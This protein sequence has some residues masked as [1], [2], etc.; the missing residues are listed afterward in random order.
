MRKLSAWYEEKS[1]TIRLISVVISGVFLALSLGL[2]W[3]GK[4]A[5]VNPAWAAIV[6]CGVPIVAGAAAGLVR[7]KDITADVLV[8]IALIGSLILKEFFAAGEVAFI[9]QIGSILEDFT[10]ERAKKGI[11]KLLKL[12][13]QKA[14]L[15]ENGAVRVIGAESVKKGDIL[16]VRAGE[17]IPVDARIIEGSTSVNQSAMT[18]ESMPVEKRAGDEVMS[19]TI[20]ESGVIL[21]EATKTAR[22]SS[23]QRMIALAESADAQK[24]KI[25]RKANV[26]AAWLVVISLATAIIS[27]FVIAK[28]CGDGWLG[29]ER[30]VTVLVVFCPCA[31]VLA[32]PTAISAGIGNASKHGVLIQSGEAL[33]RLA[34][35]D[36]AIF[37][38]TG[39]LTSGKPVVVKTESTSEMSAEEILKI[40]ASGEA[41]STHPLAKA[42]VAANKGGV[43]EISNHKTIAGWGIEFDC[44]ST[45]YRAG[46]TERE[47]GGCSL[48][49]VYEG[50][51][52][53]GEIFIRDEVK[54][55]AKEMISAL[56]TL[57]IKTAMLTGDNAQ[58]AQS[59]ASELGADEFKAECS[60]EDKMRYIKEA[61]ANGKH[62]AFFGDGVND[63]LALRTAFAG[64]AMG[65]L[66]SD[67][68]I[69]SA[70]AVIVRDNVDAIVYL[71]RIAKK[72]RKRITLNLC[73]SLAL[74]ALAVALAITGVL[75]TVSGALFHNC[76]SVFVVISAFVLLFARNNPR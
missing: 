42:I 9:M 63:T 59:V 74:N 51:K 29:F 67:A 12:N 40:A 10:S 71:F 35:A 44:N 24:A 25:V 23:L 5:A 15:W 16:Q 68:A 22:D 31:F 18:G 26:W 28:V 20:N 21:I 47:S 8:A 48:V 53:L 56:K 11:S 19:G 6:L 36:I 39:T 41:L 62:T 57:G 13:P 69:E 61:E 14:N 46:K 65:A 30:A 43:Y 37:D 45:A 52:L 55:G 60:P 7:D 75:N 72:T 17:E 64:V 27:G 4:S 1:D 54:T 2:D 70:D 73:V 3:T 32:T 34:A 49:G 76:G 66:G 50:E 33:E 38:K 58:T